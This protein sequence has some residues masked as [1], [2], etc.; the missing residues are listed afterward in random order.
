[1]STSQH[2]SKCL[3]SGRAALLKIQRH[4]FKISETVA[5]MSADVDV[6][7]RDSGKKR[8]GTTGFEPGR[9]AGTILP[10][11]TETFGA[12]DDVQSGEGTSIPGAFTMVEQPI[13][14]TKSNDVPQG[15][16]RSCSGL[17]PQPMRAYLS[18]T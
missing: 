6:T 5:Y 12:N 2:Y 3:L 4:A 16:R 8:H 9:L 7:H 13:K 10:A 14:I 1:M 18:L 15:V 11:T 17:Y